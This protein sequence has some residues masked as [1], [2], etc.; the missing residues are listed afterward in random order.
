MILLWRREC[1]H[2]PVFLP[3]EFHGQRSLAGY[4]PW[5]HTESDT[6][7]QLTHTLFLSVSLSPP[8]PLPLP[9]GTS[10]EALVVKSLAVNAGDL[11]DAASIPGWCRSP[12]RE[13]GNPPQCSSLENSMDRGAWRAIVHGVTKSQT[14]LK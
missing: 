8:F 10:Q 7:E 1:Q 2:I 13:H 11:R 4:S 12:G 3:R 5:G 6:T 14:Q 9:I